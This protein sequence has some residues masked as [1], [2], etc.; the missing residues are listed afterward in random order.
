[1]KNTLDIRMKILTESS[2][3]KIKEA[4]AVTHSVLF[5]NIARALL[6]RRMTEMALEGTPE[7]LSAIKE[8]ITATQNFQNELCSESANLES[9]ARSLKLKHEA[10]VQFECA[11]GVP[12]A[13]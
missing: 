5:S 3:T 7:Q 6:G 4:R 13:F 9:I 1:L 11:L 12:W 10:A 8:A 2:K